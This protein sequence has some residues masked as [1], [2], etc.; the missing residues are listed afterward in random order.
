MEKELEELKELKNTIQEAVSAIKGEVFDMS[1]KNENLI[2]ALNRN[3]R[4]HNVSAL[5]TLCEIS[6][7]RPY[8]NIFTTEEV[9]DIYI[10]LK[11]EFSDIAS[12]RSSR[13]KQKTKKIDLK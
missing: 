7:K 10:N 11:D 4:A 3:T 2:E 6:M 8:Y 9:M 12:V 1:V 5:I 13:G